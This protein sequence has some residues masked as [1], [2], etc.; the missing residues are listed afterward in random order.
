MK[1]YFRLAV[2]IFVLLSVTTIVSAATRSNE[3][4][5]NYYFPTYDTDYSYYMLRQDLKIEHG[6]LEVETIEKTNNYEYSVHNFPL[7]SRDYMQ[8]IFIPFIRTESFNLMTPLYASKRSIISAG[9]IEFEKYLQKYFFQAIAGLYFD[10]DFSVHLIYEYRAREDEESERQSIGDDEGRLVLARF[11]VSQTWQLV[12]FAREFSEWKTDSKETVLQAS[13]QVIWR[14]SND[15]SLMMGMPGLLSIE[16]AL[17]FD[18]ETFFYVKKE[19]DILYI[20]SAL[21]QR[22]GESFDITLRFQRDGDRLYIPEESLTISEETVAYDN[23]I[24]YEDRTELNISYHHSQNIQ[25]QLRGG[26]FHGSDI[27]LFQKEDKVGDIKS[28]SGTYVGCT[29]AFLF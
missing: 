27:E 2:V 7:Y 14:P 6:L 26:Y 29:V 10:E 22:W 5:I 1:N 16:L 17:P 13:I 18:M 15:F 11:P 3:A 19:G 25:L 9:E 20:N 12:A 4:F 8:K 21:R 23:F 28:V 24:H